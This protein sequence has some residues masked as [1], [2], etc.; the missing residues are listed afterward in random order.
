M[1]LCHNVVATKELASFILG[2]LDYKKVH[3]KLISAHW[4]SPEKKAVLHV[5]FTRQGGVLDMR[6]PN[7]YHLDDSDE[8]QW[9]DEK[10]LCK[11]VNVK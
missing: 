9:C 5:I 6:L 2:I 1:F 3:P 10:L 11:T 7:T 4:V 8:L